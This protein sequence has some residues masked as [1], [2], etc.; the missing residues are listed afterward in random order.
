[1]DGRGK[2]DRPIVPRKPSN[3]GGGGSSPAEGAEERGLAK[4][5]PHPQ[6][7]SQTQCWKDDLPS[8]RE[9]IQQAAARDRRQRF[10]AL[11]HHVYAPERLREAY[12]DLKRQ[13]APGV[14]GQRWESYG[15]EL[16]ANLRDLSD[17]LRRGAYRAR[18]VRRA[19]IPKADGRQ[20]PIGI[21]VLEDGRRTV[22]EYGTPQ[23]G[24]I[25]PL[26]ANLYLHYAFDLWVDH[27]RRTVARG[28]VVVV[29]YADDFVVGFEHR[30][31]A[32]RFLGELRERF[33][34]FHLELHADKTRLLEFGR[35][36]ARDRAACGEGKPPTFDFL[37]FTHICG[38][39]RKGRFIVR[40]RLMKKR[41]CERSSGPS[42]RS[43]ADACTGPSGR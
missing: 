1:M 13:A 38:K 41:G 34:R 20:R 31:E 8:A 2:S 17:R 11:W 30:A 42:R 9:R 26:L 29:R 23:G 21:P 33:R 22:V 43:F 25:S 19:Y 3:N 35:Y 12:F 24:S 7:K 40:Q 28:D 4:G 18:P 6:N 27:W 37:G 39:T 10:T 32:E 15:E 36:A 14:D 16:E 5:N